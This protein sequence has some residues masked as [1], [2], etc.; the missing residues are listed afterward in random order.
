MPVVLLKGT[1][2]VLL[3]K[4]TINKRISIT[5]RLFVRLSNQPPFALS[6]LYSSLKIGLSNNLML[7]T[8]SSTVS[9]KKMFTCINRQASQ[10]LLNS[11]MSISFTELSMAW[12]KLPGCD[13]IV[14][15]HFSLLKG[16][17][18]AN[19]MLLYLLETRVLILFLS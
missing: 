15:T 16:F 7:E 11:A 1:M 4:V 18:Q 2:H 17:G 13:I 3:P 10:T 14:F 5:Q 12:S 9:F 19:A 8:P 6:L